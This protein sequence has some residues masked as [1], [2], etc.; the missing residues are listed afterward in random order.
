VRVG[1][2]ALADHELES[3]GLFTPVPG[4]FS[5]WVHRVKLHSRG[6][7]DWMFPQ[8]IPKLRLEQTSTSTVL[9]VF[10]AS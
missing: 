5:T 2:R 8:V 9:E 10:L 3:S 4:R 7:F 1:E 6:L